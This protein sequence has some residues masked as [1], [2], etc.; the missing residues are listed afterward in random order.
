MKAGGCPACHWM[1]DANADIYSSP[2]KGRGVR[3]Y[4]AFFDFFCLPGGFP[5]DAD[6]N[7]ERKLRI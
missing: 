3:D 2:L 6:R 1:R 4:Y 5:L 7:F